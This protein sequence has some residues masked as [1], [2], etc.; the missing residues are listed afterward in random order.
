MYIVGSQSRRTCSLKHVVVSDVVIIMRSH[1]H[2][3]EYFENQLT[4]LSTR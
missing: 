2:N 3:F 4:K 1:G